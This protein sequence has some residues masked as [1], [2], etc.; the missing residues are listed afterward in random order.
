MGR[1]RVPTF[2]VGSYQDEQTGGHFAD[3]P[4]PARATTRARGSRCRTASTPTRSARARSPAGWSSSSST[5]PTRCRR[6][7]DP[8]L[9]LSDALYAFLA[10]APA[11]PVQQS[12]FAGGTDVAAARADV[13]A[14]PARAAADGERR[15]PGRPRLD[16]RVVGARLRRLADPRGRRR[17]T[18]FLGAG[19]ALTPGGARARHRRATSPTR[20]HARPRRCPGTATPTPGRPSRP[21]TGSRSP[22]ARA[23][24]SPRRRCTP[25]VVVAGDARLDL[26]ISASA[27]DT[28]LQVT[29]SEIRPDGA[30]TYVQNGW[31]RASHRNG[32]APRSALEP[33]PRG[34]DG[35]RARADPPRRARLPRRLAH[36]RHRRRRP[37]AT[38]RAGASTPSTTA[39]RA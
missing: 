30:E 27:G 33:I 23:S 9:G 11:A 16:R 35:H 3:E 29:L 7:P 38:G 32:H 19:G 21:T 1:I 28:D 15:R 10:D 36:P 25:D 24:A 4:R 6:C 20:P 18:F 8:V 34:G 5:S 13:R 37:A 31:L 39:R 26:R 17:P 14:G 12:R 2:L 22:T